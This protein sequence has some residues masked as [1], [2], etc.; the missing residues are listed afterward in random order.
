MPKSFKKSK[1]KSKNENVDEIEKSIRMAENH[2]TD[3]EDQE[4]D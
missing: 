3:K 2:Q 1:N 4:E